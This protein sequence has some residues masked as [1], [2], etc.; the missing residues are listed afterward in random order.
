[1]VK[2]AS[3]VAKQLLF[4]MVDWSSPAIRRPLDFEL[5]TCE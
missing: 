5:L 1:M 4:D 3:S 2:N